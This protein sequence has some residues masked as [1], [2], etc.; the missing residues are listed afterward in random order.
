M[1]ASAV[2]FNPQ[3]RN[4]LAVALTNGALDVWDSSTGLRVHEIGR[5]DGQPISALAYSSDGTRL[6]SAAQDGA[7]RIWPVLDW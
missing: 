1:P 7:A 2:A 5:T 3:I 4:S 6:V